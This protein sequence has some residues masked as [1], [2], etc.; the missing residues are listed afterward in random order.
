MKKAFRFAQFSSNIAIVIIAIM[1]SIVVI[2]QYISSPVVADTKTVAKQTNTN[3]P[4][5]KPEIQTPVGKTVPMQDVNWKENKK[6]L[7]LYMSTNCRYCKESVP[8]YQ[9]LV[10]ETADK[11]VKF[12]AV[13]PQ[14]TEEA[15]EYFKSQNVEIKDIYN[16]SLSS[17]G[18]VATPILLLVNEQGVV[19]DY[20]RGKLPAEK[21]SDVL[22]KLAS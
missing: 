6:T 1:L 17:I 18:V 9:K 2:K 7:V 19:S 14:T 13:L 3:I 12:V 4:T 16:A 21:E 5:A 15:T 10:K 8:F 11:K 22:A 20:W